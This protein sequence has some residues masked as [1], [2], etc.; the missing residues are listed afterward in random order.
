MED[1]IA[2]LRAKF[3]H[4]TPKKPQHSPLRHTPINY[5]A[6]FQYAAETPSSPPLNNSSKLRIQQLV[7]AIQYYARAVDNKL[8]VALSKLAQQKSSPT[9]DTNTDMLQ[10]LD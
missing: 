4:P 8:L 10:L 9:K 5:G 3:G 2:N 7:G 1:Y 6:N